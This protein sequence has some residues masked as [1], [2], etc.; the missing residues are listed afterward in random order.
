MLI[1]HPVMLAALAGLLSIVAAVSL[2][3]IGADW[4][5]RTPIANDPILYAE[6]ASRVLDGAVPYTNVTVEHLPM[7]LVPILFVGAV[8]RATSISYTIL[9]PLVTVGAV[10]ATTAMAGRV[11]LGD[12]YQRRFVIAILPMLPLI[13]FRLEIYVLFAAVAAIASFSVSRYR[14]GSIWTL[15]GLLAKGWPITLLM[16]PWRKGHRGLALG[17]IAL[18]TSLLVLVAVTPGFRRGR[19]FAGIHSETVVGNLII[20]YRHLAGLD[21]GIV[22]VAGAAYTSAPLIAIA[23]NASIALPILAIAVWFFLRA[24]ATMRLVSIAGLATAGIILL[25]PLFSAQFTFW[26]A[27]FVV[28]ASRRTRTAYLVAG[29]LSLIVAALW[30]PTEF[31]WAIEVL[32]R[33]AAFLVVVALWTLDLWTA[34]GTP[35][36][37]PSRSGEHVA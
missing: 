30:S 17:V 12:N 25:S 4:P 36:V 26:L 9:W 28:L 5:Q 32:I 29:G 22:D 6:I 23:L 37:T 15:I 31:W 7:A 3:V 35:S 2:V 24:S 8:A 21:P 10:V 33:N 34:R 13:I 27:P 1:K 11:T 20:I 18:G 14:S 16:V 19:S